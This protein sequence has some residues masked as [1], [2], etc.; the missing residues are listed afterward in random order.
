MKEGGKVLFAPGIVDHQQAAAI[1]EGLGELRLGSLQT[2]EGGL[3]TRQEYDQLGD[4]TD[5]IL[6]LLA[7]NHAEDA[8]A[9][10][11]L[12]LWVVAQRVG[13]GRLAEAAGAAKGSGDRDRLA[14]RV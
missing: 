2:G 12:D 10:G 14:L 4:A 5:E 9:E 13:E 3:L 11:V 6:R 7:E 1:I 8:I